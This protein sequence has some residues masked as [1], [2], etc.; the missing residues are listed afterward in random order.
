MHFLNFN[1]AEAKLEY[2]NRQKFCISFT[3]IFHSILISEKINM[4]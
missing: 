3:V 1:Q 2:E 4:N